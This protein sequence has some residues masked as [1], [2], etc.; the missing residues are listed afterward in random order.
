MPHAD[1]PRFLPDPDTQPEF[2][3]DVATKRL[4]AFLVDVVLIALLTLIA[5]VLSLFILSFFAP[6]LYAVISFV[7]RTMSLANRSAT[8]GMRL[9]AIEMRTLNG[10]PLSLPMAAAH[11]L[12]TTMSFAVFPVQI[13]SVVMML[14]TPRG[15]GLTDHVIGTVALNKRAGY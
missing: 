1:D 6:L 8:P 7:Y 14:M 12:G 13:A 15:Q 9:M 2:Y 3:A 4:L 5:I 10:A 11:T